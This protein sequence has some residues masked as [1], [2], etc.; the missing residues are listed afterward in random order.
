MKNSYT[1]REVVKG[2]ILGSFFL[3]TGCNRHRYIRQAEELDLGAVEDLLY[4]KVHLRKHALVVFRDIDGW[5]ALSARCT[6][7]GCDLTYQDPVLL[8]PCCRSRFT[9]SGVPYSGYKAKEPLPWCDIYYKDGHLYANPGK[10]QTSKFRF[11]TP[12][13]ENAIRELRKQT[14]SEVLKG[15]VQ[16]PE[17]L[18]GK[19]DNDLVGGQFLEEDPNVV[20]ELQMLK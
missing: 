11:T 3:A 18:L 16:I 2:A 13:I 8:C 7:I 1:R 12:E 14:K 19:G 17:V 10:V 6:Y 9:L 5:S 20:H 4:D 15:S